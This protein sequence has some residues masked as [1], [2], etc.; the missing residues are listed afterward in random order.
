[1]RAVSFAGATEARRARRR[2]S[3]PRSHPAS[4]ALRSASARGE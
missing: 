3:K 2:S 1:M 4:D